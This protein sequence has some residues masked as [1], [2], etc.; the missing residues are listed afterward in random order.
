MIFNSFFNFKERHFHF[1]EGASQYQ[2]EITSEK[3]CTWKDMGN[4]AYDLKKNLLKV[5]LNGIWRDTPDRRKSLSNAKIE[6]Q[7]YSQHFGL[8]ITVV[9]TTILINSS[10]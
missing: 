6:Q 3:S 4:I 1:V 5:C 10:K 9:M 2:S 8:K 7:C